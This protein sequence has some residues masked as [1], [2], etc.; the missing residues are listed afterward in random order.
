M[1]NRC[2][3]TV[4]TGLTAGQVGPNAPGYYPGQYGW[5]WMQGGYIARPGRPLKEFTGWWLGG[6]PQFYYPMG[7]SGSPGA[8]G[9]PA[10]GGSDSG[11]GSIAPPAPN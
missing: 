4:R 6:N 2:N 9:A 5:Y 8:F 7:G 11:D 3:L 1:K 10:L